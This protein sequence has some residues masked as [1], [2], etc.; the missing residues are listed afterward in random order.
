[1]KNKFFDELK[2][3][4][5]FLRYSVYINIGQFFLIILTVILIAM[6]SQTKVLEVT[7][8]PGDYEGHTFKVGL[9]DASNETY[10]IW[11]EVFASRGGTFSTE[12]VEDKTKW[13]M[14]F[15]VPD[16][17]FLLQTDF[18]KLVSEV[19]SNFI[20]SKFHFKMAKVVRMAG[21]VTVFNYG[22][23]DRWVGTDQVMERIPYVYE[24]DM[25]VKNSNIMFGRFNGHIDENPF[26]TGSEQGKVHKETSSYVNFK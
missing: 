16:R 26:A 18:D 6:A 22:T 2:E 24:I 1:M 13:L 20:T 19:K 11:G 23:M 9:N 3:S 25:V 12:N 14:K 15:S 17:S 4:Q 7:I 10:Q 5:A 8:P 21:Y